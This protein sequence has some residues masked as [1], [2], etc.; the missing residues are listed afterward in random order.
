MTSR[1]PAQDEMGEFQYSIITRICL[2]TGAWAK[3]K[4]VKF[5]FRT[6]QLQPGIDG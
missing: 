5:F 2:P 1:S 4:T 3:C 6:V